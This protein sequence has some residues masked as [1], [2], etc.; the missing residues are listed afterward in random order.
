MFFFEKNHNQI[1]SNFENF[2]NT[3]P[4]LVASYI[5]FWYLE[6]TGYGRSRIFVTQAFNKIVSALFWDCVLLK[7]EDFSFTWQGTQIPGPSICKIWHGPYSGPLPRIWVQTRR[8]LAWVRDTESPLLEVIRKERG[9]NEGG[10][11]FWGVHGCRNLTKLAAVCSVSTQY[12][13]KY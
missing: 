10:A 9:G 4:T 6:K 8:S 13:N 3:C 2:Q 5:V 7:L 12:N 1:F 11:G